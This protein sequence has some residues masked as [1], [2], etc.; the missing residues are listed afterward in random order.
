MV[1]EDF[2]LNGDFS[3]IFENFL[4]LFVIG[5]LFEILEIIKIKNEVSKVMEYVVV[6]VVKI[7]F[8]FVFVFEILGS[9]SEGIKCG[10]FDEFDY[11][12]IM[13]VFLKCF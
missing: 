4:K 9:M 6:K 2:S 13:D 7:S 11:L 10:F 12:C 3:K 5:K 1:S 8:L